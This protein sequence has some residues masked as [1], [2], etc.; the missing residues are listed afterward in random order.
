MKLLTI[1]GT[2][3]FLEIKDMEQ[4]IIMQSKPDKQHENPKQGS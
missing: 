4:L 2:S 1:A 3:I